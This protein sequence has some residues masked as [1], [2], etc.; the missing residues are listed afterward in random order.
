MDLSEIMVKI[1]E[2][3]VYLSIE[4]IETI[5]QN[6]DF[7]RDFKTDMDLFYDI[8]DSW[9]DWNFPNVTYQWEKALGKYQIFL[10]EEAKRFCDLKPMHSHFNYSPLYFENYLH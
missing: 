5:K 10:F 3:D 1:G 7:G 6:V 4:E 8:P 9:Q 2:N